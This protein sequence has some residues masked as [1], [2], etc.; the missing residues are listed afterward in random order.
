MSIV[1]M[2]KDTAR[3][4]LEDKVPRLAAALAFYTIL[5]AAPLLVIVLAIAGLVFQESQQVQ[6]MLANQ[7]SNLIG[8]EGGE[9]IQTMIAHASRPD[10]SVT[11]MIIGAIVLLVG[12]SGVF[13]ELQDSLNTIWEVAPKPGRGILMTIRDRF[14]SL[15]MVF[16]SGF[17]LLVTLVISTVLAALTRFAGLEKIGVVGQI[18]NFCVSFGVITLLFAM[19]Y[20]Y[21]P[22]V[23]I[24]WRDVWIGALVTAFLF[25]FGKWLIG[26]Y[27]GQASVGSAYGTAGSLVVFVV[28]VYYSAQ[29]LFL[30]AEFT[31]V[32][33]N[34]V[35]SHIQPTENAIAVTNEARAQQG[36]TREPAVPGARR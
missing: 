23:K 33:A 7:L 17:L 11:A 26:L 4:W 19:L 13:A 15:V 5:S 30:G 6:T 16:G 1:R 12:A 34:T 36:L 3:T 2:S 8:E 14:L 20:K 31:K 35:G 22:D 27:L 29:I 9:A 28:W 25:T 32:Y 24:A 18:I 21:L 10:S